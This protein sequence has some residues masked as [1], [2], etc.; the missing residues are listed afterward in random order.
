[1]KLRIQESE[2]DNDSQKIIETCSDCHCATKVIG[3]K[4]AKRLGEAGAKIAING[5]S[6]SVTELV[7]K[8]LDVLNK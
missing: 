4:I 2:E 7:K 3:L 5:R 6:P 8:A 1:M